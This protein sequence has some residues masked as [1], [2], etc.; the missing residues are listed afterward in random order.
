MF[1]PMIDEKIIIDSKNIDTFTRELGYNPVEFQNTTGKNFK[2]SL[3]Q[4]IRNL[5]LY[6]VL[7]EYLSHEIKEYISL[8][9]KYT[10]T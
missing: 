10:S 6:F 9:D 5:N 8:P 4:I 1:P 3:D 7:E 2:I